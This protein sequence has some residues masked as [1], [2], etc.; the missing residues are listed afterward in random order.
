MF[1][2]GT[3]EHE[4]QITL[5]NWCELYKNKYPAL[6]MLFAIPNGGARHIAV[7]IKLKKEGVKRG[8]PD[9]FLAYPNK[10][11]HG[12]FIEMKALKGKKT[13]EQSW[14]I[15]KLTD[16]EY[17]AKTCYGWIEAVKTICSYLGIDPVSTRIRD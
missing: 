1:V 12:L 8:V 13:I 14:W 7:A 4:E 6:N 3:S 11:K 15:E 5:I 10:G 16:K 17:E 9:L 2:N